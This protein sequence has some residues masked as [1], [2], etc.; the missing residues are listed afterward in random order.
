MLKPLKAD[1]VLNSVANLIGHLPGD[2]AFFAKD[3]SFRIIAG[4]ENLCHR[5]GASMLDDLLGK[6]DHELFPPQMAD[7]FRL[8]DE[9]VINTG[10]ASITRQLGS[11]LSKKL[12]AT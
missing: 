12:S 1:V 8:H 10:E 11:R 4:N 7:N 5:V 9:R 3:T 6:T 2:V